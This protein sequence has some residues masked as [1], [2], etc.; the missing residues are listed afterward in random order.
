MKK[1]KIFLFFCVVVC[2]FTTMRA[3]KQFTLNSPDG[4]LQTTVTIGEKLTYDITCN[5]RQILAS[6][7]ISMTLDNGEV[8]GEKAKLSGTA[9][10]SIDRMVP[11]PFYRA[12][13]LR[14]CYNELTLRFKKD[15]N[16]EFRAYND[17]IVYRFVSRS[18]KPFN[19]VDEAVDY[20]FPNDMIATV[21]Y[22]KSGKDGDFN[23]QFFNSFENTYTTDKLSKLNKQRLMFLPLVVD[24]GEGVKL[25]LTESDLENYPGLYLSVAEGENSLK[26]TFAPYPKH[27]E[28]GGHNKLQ[29]LVKERE[30]YIAKV[31][32]PRNFPWRM[33]I[34]T[35]ADKDLA[36]S[37]LSYLLAAPSRLSDISWIK[38]GKVAWEWWNAWNLD[39]VDFVTGV[40]NATYKA[41]IDFAAAKGIEYVILDEGWAVN[42]KADLMQVVKEIDL[43]ELVDYAASKNVGIILWAGY[44][45]FDRDMENV[46]RHYAAMGVKGFKVDFMDRDDQE[47]TAF[48]YR[49]AEMCAKYKLILDLHG[50]HKPAGMNRTYPNVLNFEGVNGLEQMK[51]SPASLDQ[52]K[53]DV[54]IPF[55]RQ[56][57]GPMDYTQGAMRNAS[58]GNYYPCNSEPMSQGTRCRQLALYVVFESPFNM[59]C[60][61]PGNYMREPESTDFIAGIPTVWDESIV[62]DGKMG[63]YIVTA[64][65]Q[66]NV[67]YVGGIT[68]WTARDI[69]VDCSFL[70]D[71][72]TY[73]ATLFKDGVNAHRIGRDYK[74]ESLS[75]KK[76]G[77][78][79]IHLAPGGGFA[80]QIK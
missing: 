55:I 71:D 9:K 66:G 24:A 72:K 34:V 62:L 32:K 17:G 28:Q 15:W 37:N 29:M 76:D 27:T 47:M 42:L 25:C 52:V 61:N 68:D 60:D 30:A 35:T 39:G 8:W 75:I 5:G 56:V 46:C 69:E 18:K 22:V 44:Y 36:A 74:R 59:L 78:L 45:A 3:Q 33:A 58:K 40:N 79:K 41:Y 7:P 11:S 38:P 80:L 63:E 50:T 1:L 10:K 21:P 48:N 16:V 20:R 13:E 6:S 4:K 12:S 53:Y 67:W 70:G 2:T 65:R 77:K 14:D 19:V 54:M 57:S 49:A 51:W 31:D 26:G 73:N 23:S 43:K 64:R